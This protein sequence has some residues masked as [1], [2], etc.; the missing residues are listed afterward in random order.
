MNLIFAQKSTAE[1]VLCKDSSSLRSAS[2]GW[3]RLFISTMWSLQYGISRWPDFLHVSSRLPRP[4]S[5]EREPGESCIAFYGLASEVMQPY[6][7][8]SLLIKFQDQ[9]R[10]KG[11]G[12]RFTSMGGMENNC[13]HVRSSSFPFFLFFF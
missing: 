5:Q 2:T 9:P 4:V 1:A 8:H 12:N 13:G 11:L 6:F 7:R 10:F 3:A